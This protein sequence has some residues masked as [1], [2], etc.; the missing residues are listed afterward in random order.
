MPRKDLEEFIRQRLT[1]LD[2]LRD[3]SPG[4]PADTEV[5]TPILKYFGVDLFQTD[6]RSFVL[7]TLRQ[8]HPE[9][10]VRADGV[11]DDAVG[12]PFSTLASGLIREILL[13]KS[14][15]RPDPR[16]HT[17]DSAQDLLGAL[18]VPLEEGGR[19]FGKFRF[20]Y[21]API[22]EIIRPESVIIA[23]NGMRF[24]PTETQSI[25]QA[26]M[27]LNYRNGRYYF[28]VSAVATTPGVTGNLSVGSA[29]R[30]PSVTRSVGVECIEQMV[31]GVDA[32]TVSGYLSKARNYPTQLSFSVARGIKAILAREFSGAA[33]RVEVVGMGDPEMARDILRGGNFGPAVAHDIGG[34]GMPSFTLDL[35]TDVFSDLGANVSML[36]VGELTDDYYLIV[37][38]TNKPS[39]IGEGR[40]RRVV[41]PAFPVI[42]ELDD[43][44]VPLG[45]S[46]ATWE[47]RRRRITISEVPGGFLDPPDPG[48]TIEVRDGEIHLGGMTDIHV[49]GTL[50]DSSSDIEVA[51]DEDELAS[52]SSAEA[53]GV[54]TWVNPAGW[55]RLDIPDTV[56]LA[57]NASGIVLDSLARP[58]GVQITGVVRG[59]S[60]L[61]G[62]RVSPGLD[63]E[64]G[65]PHSDIIEILIAGNWVRYQLV[66]LTAAGGP[67]SSFTFWTER[68]ILPSPLP[69]PTPVRIVRPM[70]DGVDPP[71]SLLSILRSPEEYYR[72]VEWR[73]GFY[74]GA[75]TD[76]RNY[77][78]EVRVY[79]SPDVSSTYPT[80]E[81]WVLVDDVDIDLSDPRRFRGSGTDLN[82]IP[83][84]SAVSTISGRNME[85]LGVQAE[86][87]LRILTGSDAGDYTIDKDPS[88]PGKSILQL[89]ER[90]VSGGPVAYEI[91]APQTPINLPLVDVR[92]A[93]LLD[94]ASGVTGSTIPLGQP[95]GAVSSQFANA[96]SGVKWRKAD[97][98]VGI[99][100]LGPMTGTWTPGVADY[101]DL[102][103]YSR[104]WG[105]ITK[106]HQSGGPYNTA[107]AIDVVQLLTDLNYGLP[108]DYFF[109]MRPDGTIAAPTS[110]VDGE[111]LYLAVAPY[112][113]Y[114]D[115]LVAGVNLTGVG[116]A[117]GIFMNPGS[118]GALLTSRT[119]T[120]FDITSAM[121]VERLSIAAWN[122]SVLI[123]TGLNAGVSGLVQAM[124]FTFSNMHLMLFP[125]VGPLR[126]QRLATARVGSPSV[127][128]GRTFFRDPTLFEV[129][130]RS[131]YVAE[132]KS[133]VP[134]PRV[135]AT[136][137]P[138]YPDTVKPSG[139]AYDPTYIVGQRWFELP[140][141]YADYDIDILDLLEPDC[142]D[143][144]FLYNFALGPWTPAAGTYTFNFNFENGSTL[145]VNINTPGGVPFDRP[146]MLAT[147]NAVL[148]PLPAT[149]LAIEV[150]DGP[151]QMLGI[152][153]QERITS[154]T[155]NGPAA[156]SGM[157]PVTYATQGNLSYLAQ[158]NQIFAVLAT[159]P[160]DPTYVRTSGPAMVSPYEASPLTNVQFKVR[161]MGQQRFSAKQ[162]SENIHDSSLYYADVE[163]ISMGAGDDWNIGPDLSFL[164]SGWRA[165]GY[166]LRPDNPVLSFSTKETPIFSATPF[167]QDPAV[168]DSYQQQ[169]PVYGSG[170]RLAYERDSLVA[171]VQTL[172]ESEDER[173]NNESV[174]ARCM[175]PCEVFFIVE[176]Q[177]GLPES[178][179]RVEIEKLVTEK[180]DALDV[181]DIIYRLQQLGATS[182][183][184]PVE[185]G[186]AYVE[187]DRT[188]RL[189]LAKDRVEVTRLAAFLV[190]RITLRR[191]G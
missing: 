186:A 187:Q 133:F 182:V 49:L 16:I 33:R 136:K 59:G 47:I 188:F 18:F 138:A 74:Q 22:S 164:L 73:N 176:Y 14:R 140:G 70:P 141:H 78:A 94:S 68:D 17:L 27:R 146:T 32:D 52:G 107:L 174:L 79:P 112:D 189:V 123:E 183:Q 114:E 102:L 90:L 160:D 20:Y 166:H 91:F 120:F 179:M 92:S 184:L 95:L 24:V 122:D 155:G 103:V 69:L 158:K 154:V 185:I 31:G 104:A 45:I 98:S 76:N 50:E 156:L 180:A 21:T 55:I 62:L 153:T 97:C 148:S 8:A 96:G 29:V 116:T 11:I 58:R 113:A 65:S 150:N 41:N 177:G 170:V 165:L 168:S 51:S 106:R 117:A 54:T 129:D 105:K 131:R 26:E 99:V 40:I 35:R 167:I 34:A 118:T 126:P 162:I 175:R 151:I 7:D 159:A 119:V 30:C 81:A 43:P 109:A 56:L 63:A 23:A 173:E 6:V 25:S 10:G 87:I 142:R 152:S 101:L 9:L 13:M 135:K 169:T 12:K 83:G 171:S 89:R 161:R 66:A 44:I 149:P 67:G 42:L 15:Q 60:D 5:I 127:G 19:S 82:P 139:L 143:I 144:W 111:E 172:A 57:D 132:G 147:F 1:A 64:T 46:G 157:E 2:P 137:C 28:D 100:G 110:I 38:P 124:S 36:G 48:G 115:T 53:G 93:I 128:L 80:G 163:L 145:T 84:S 72:V 121:L 37:H 130:D 190:G 134:D 85:E 77:R 108:A 178:E 75:D 191:L 88:G 181:S 39:T 86:D 4:S 3:V 61:S 71:R 125:W